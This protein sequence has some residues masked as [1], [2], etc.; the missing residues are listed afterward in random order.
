[1]PLTIAVTGS[2]GM[3][4]SAVCQ[5]ALEDGHTVIG[6]DRVSS[7]IRHPNFIAKIVD[8]TNYE[9]LSEGMK[10][11]DSLVHLA[12]MVRSDVTPQ[13]VIHNINVVSSYNALKIA[14]DRGIRRV[15]QASSVNVIG[16]AFSRRPKLD[17]LPLDE[18]HPFYA[19]DAYSLSKCICEYQ[20]SAIARRNPQMHIASLRFHW[21]V[22][23][24]A[25]AAKMMS[26]ASP[27][28]EFYA[29]HARDLWGWVSR[30]AAARACLLGLTAP[31]DAWQGHEPFFIVA[32]NTA[33]EQTSADL[34]TEA[35][36]EV[37]DIRKPW[38]GNA[39]FF[40]C[41]KAAKLLGWWEE[42][43]DA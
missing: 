3:L 33:V 26:S 28:S 24:R 34:C 25:D 9:Q 4:G 35:Y 38:V 11:C 39:S 37:T 8:T 22:P 31:E 23:S 32:P 6:L 15:V 10:G 43:I 18:S 16:L 29:E 2:E 7:N 1:M 21:I 40:D 13:E 17:Y 42:D 41:A 5:Y 12:A 30:R 27:D 36:P 19:E 20:A 14:A